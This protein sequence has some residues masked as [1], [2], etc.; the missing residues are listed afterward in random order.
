MH[1]IGADLAN[2]AA[3]RLVSR[4]SFPYFVVPRYDTVVRSLVPT[5]AGF[6]RA[7]VHVGDVSREVWRTNWPDIVPADSQFEL[8][9]L[10][11]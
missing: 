10:Q 7:A 4:Y 2:Y 1:Q 8:G 9:T 11:D 6:Q 5:Q 3:N